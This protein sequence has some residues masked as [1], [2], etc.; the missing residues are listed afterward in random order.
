MLVMQYAMSSRTLM[1]VKKNFFFLP[2]FCLFSP[3]IIS[4]C[5]LVLVSAFYVQDPNLVKFLFILATPHSV[6]DLSSQT[7]D[8]T[9]TLCSGSVESEPLDRQGVPCCC[10]CC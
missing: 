7:T 3:E 5:L 1:V 4:S 10:C 6:W 8:E 2:E 9:H